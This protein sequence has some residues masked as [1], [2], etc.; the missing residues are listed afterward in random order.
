MANCCCHL[1]GY[2]IKDAYA[3]RQ[4][5]NIDELVN[6]HYIQKYNATLSE[7]VRTI[8]CNKDSN[9]NDL[10]LK[11]L[12]INANFPIPEDMVNCAI[13]V[14][15]SGV[16]TSEENN[17]ETMTINLGEF[18]S[19]DRD[20]FLHFTIYNRRGTFILEAIHGTSPYEKN[21][22][23][24]EYDPVKSSNFPYI[25]GVQIKSKNAYKFPVGSQITIGGIDA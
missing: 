20:T 11:E 16:N 6:P 7:E 14:T 18:L 17:T 8:S 15:V 19:Y 25:T 24:G 1:N 5:K 22:V 9:G 23:I 10:K 3:R 2:E 12:N 21:I 4:L 13:I